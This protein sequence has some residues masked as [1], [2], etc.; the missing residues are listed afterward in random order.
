MRL[1]AEMIAI[2]REVSIVTVVVE[3]KVGEGCPRSTDIETTLIL[4]LPSL[5]ET[6]AEETI[7]LITIESLESDDTERRCEHIT[8]AVD[9]GD[10]MA[11]A[12]GGLTLHIQAPAEVA[13]VDTHVPESA[14]R[15]IVTA[16]V[17][18]KVLDEGLVVGYVIS[19]D[20]GMPA[21]MEEVQISTGEEFRAV[22]L[23][24]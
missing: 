21:L 22:I 5:R 13:I 18:A 11:V 7:E 10:L 1:L 24:L 8:D 6:I 20:A 23:F 19:S 3:G 15:R 4:Y 14:A 16:I 17:M 2:P 12:C 9:G